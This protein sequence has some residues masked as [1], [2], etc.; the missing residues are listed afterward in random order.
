M[1]IV[2]YMLKFKTHITNKNKEWITFVH[3]FYVK[4]VHIWHKQVR[5]LHKHYNLLF[6]DL[7]GHG[8][9]KGIP[10]DYDFNLSTVL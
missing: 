6:V 1:M 3:G 8:K 9:S 10:L 2:I 7:R 4:L 5:D